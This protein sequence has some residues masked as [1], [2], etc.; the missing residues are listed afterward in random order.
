VPDAAQLETLA[1][2]PPAEGMAAEAALCQWAACLL[3]CPTC[4][5]LVTAG[6]HDPDW[7]RQWWGHAIGP[8]LATNIWHMQLLRELADPAPAAPGGPKEEAAVAPPPAADLPCGL[9]ELPPPES[10]DEEWVWV[11]DGGSADVGEAE[12]SSGG[13]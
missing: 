13:H 9:K 2:W 6:R 7:R 8:G 10:D 12:E 11:P 3:W 5:R 1:T 4:G